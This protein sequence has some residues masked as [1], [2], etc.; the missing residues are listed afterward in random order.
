MKK[1]ESK[2]PKDENLDQQSEPKISASEEREIEEILMSANETP[3]DQL[4]ISEIGEL[5]SEKENPH[6]SEE[7]EI[8]QEAWDKMDD[9]MDKVLG[10]KKGEAPAKDAG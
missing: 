10:V 3:G 7:E 4:T 1:D 5:K 8:T 2:D 9:L 6:E